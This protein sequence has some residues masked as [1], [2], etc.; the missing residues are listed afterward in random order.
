V[1]DE[2]FDAACRFLNALAASMQRYGVSSR[3]MEWQLEAVARGL[4]LQSEFRATPTQIESILW[5]EGE[6]GQRLHVVVS[7]AGNY[8]LTRL[9]Q[10]T[11]LARQVEAGTVTTTAGWNRLQA[12]DGAKP[13]FGPWLDAVAF[14]LC[15]L[16]FAVIL[17]LS[18]LD[19]LLGG[20]LSLVSFGITR[21]AVHSEGLTNALELVVA[22][23]AAA[24]ATLLCLVFPGSNALG[25]AVCAVIYF[26]PG[27]GLT[28]GASE[29]MVGNTLSGL[30]GFTR[31]AVT[32]GKLFLGAMLGGALVR[33][34]VDGV[35][36]PDVGSGAPHGWTWVF[37]PMLVL[38]LSLLFRVRREDLRWPLLGGFL[39]WA[40]VEA[41]AG[42]GFWQG[43]FIGAFG[44]TAAARHFERRTGLPATIILL[45]AIMVL[46][47]GVG[48]L[49]AFYAVE[50]HGLVAGI[51]ASWDVFVLIG[52]IMGGVLLG[53]AVSSV[54]RPRFPPLV[55]KLVRPSSKKVESHRS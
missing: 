14:S 29:L 35:P 43:T 31:A 6:D 9:V 10:L 38:G 5:R 48:A 23:V 20:A 55:S 26:V 4:N 17:G 47:P 42:F 50:T 18:W 33:G 1:Q 3:A 13:R 54:P 45:P 16:G 49:R 19:V 2:D 52:A 53:E 24:L 37:V 36:L 30:I 8:D 15:G 21:L 7:S 22:L 11:E 27:F 25:V 12:I 40:G 32:S 44:L 34:A 51:R 28:L 39:V 41:G 46:V